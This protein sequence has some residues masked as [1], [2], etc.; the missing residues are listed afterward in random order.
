M[1]IVDPHGVISPHDQV[2]SVR[3]CI[4]SAC[5]TVRYQFDRRPLQYANITGH[6]PRQGDRFESIEIT[7]FDAHHKV[8]GVAIGTSIDL[9]KFKT[10]RDDPCACPPDLHIAYDNAAERFVVSRR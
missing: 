6:Y 7:T 2:A 1:E 5:H 3:V 10:S 4:D 9:Q 8:V